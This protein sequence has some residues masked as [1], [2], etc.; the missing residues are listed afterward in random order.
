MRGKTVRKTGP[1]RDKKSLNI[2]A[3][4]F[5]PKWLLNAPLG[6]SWALPQPRWQGQIGPWAQRRRSRQ[7]RWNGWHNSFV[8]KHQ[9][10]HNL[11]SVC[12]VWTNRP[13][14]HLLVF[15]TVVLSE[16]SHSFQA[17]SFTRCVM[18][19]KLI[20]QVFPL[21]N[22]L[23]ANEIRFL[24]EGKRYVCEFQH[25]NTFNTPSISSWTNLPIFPLS[26]RWIWYLKTLL[27]LASHKSWYFYSNFS[28]F[29]TKSITLWYIFPPINELLVV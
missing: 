4:K 28:G 1:N 21:E 25:T 8:D 27:R 16:S 12:P 20:T 11:L 9:R 17:V 26:D 13:K 19:K 18:G 5:M 23:T 6:V 7:E 15:F 29:T 14:K 2:N 10:D 3:Q 22:S 24:F